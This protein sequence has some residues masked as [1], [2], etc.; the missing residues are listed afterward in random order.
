MFASA[1]SVLPP[2]FLPS[3][4]SSLSSSHAL[5]R[6][7][8]VKAASVG[9]GSD[10][11]QSPL[12]SSAKG[13]NPL[14]AVLELPRS[15]WWQT[16]QPL[17]DFGFGRTSVWEG[18]V[19][20][21]MVSG[22]VLFALAIAWLRG[23]QLR[24]RFRKY[25]VV[26]QFSQACGICVGTPVRIRGVNVGSVV[27][28]DSTVRSIDAVAEVEDD[29]IILPRNSL[30]EVNQS[31]LLMETLIDITPRDPL[32]ESSVGP[33]DADCVKEG[34]IVCDKEKIRGQQGVSLDAL[35]GVFTRL[36]QEMDEI[37]IS[38]SYRLAE[39]VASVVEEAQPL[40]AKIEALAEGVQPLLAEVRDSTLLKDVENLTKSLAEATV[41][42]RTVRSAI[43]TP[44]NAELTRQSIFTLIFTLK[45]I[46]SI[47]SDI[48]GFTGDVAA[49]RN[50]KMLIKSL[51]RL[52]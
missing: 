42:L 17:G 51:S 20:L 52:L 3:A 22:A 40:L 14:A 33:L 41:D 26:F 32:P 24:S 13:K 34:L 5:K 47:T 46:E 50:L 31:G 44:E 23:V 2:P 35:V 29:K 45:N 11:N 1:N 16:M 36:G 30:V 19:G 27:R 8:R 18:A 10:A 7:L 25:Q 4:C 21:F 37:G 49:R 39:K 38:R 6:F 12:T 48:S 28:V 9:S 15:L 43:L